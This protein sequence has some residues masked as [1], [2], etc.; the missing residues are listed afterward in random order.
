MRS[1]QQTGRLISSQNLLVQPSCRSL[2]ACDRP[3]AG[4]DKSLPSVPRS[5]GL[6]FAASALRPSSHTPVS[7]STAGDGSGYPSS[8]DLNLPQPGYST[9]ISLARGFALGSVLPGAAGL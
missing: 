5:P 9:D 1:A 2:H 8:K 7:L 6:S 3:I 4:R